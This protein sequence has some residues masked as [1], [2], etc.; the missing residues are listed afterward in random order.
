[1]AVLARTD[2]SVQAICGRQ[3][4]IR[5]YTLSAEIRIVLC[6]NNKRGWL[7]QCGKYLTENIT[8]LSPKTGAFLPAMLYEARACPATYH[9]DTIMPS[10]TFA[11]R[12]K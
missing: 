2:S 5:S 12:L 1:M 9:C 3:F 8:L 7:F 6:G 11:Q 10:T 4:P